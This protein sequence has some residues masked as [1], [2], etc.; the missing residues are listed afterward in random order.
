MNWDEILKAKEQD[1][2]NPLEL[3]SLYGLIEGVDSAIE[4]L[5]LLHSKH[6]QN[7]K[8]QVSPAKFKKWFESLERDKRKFILELHEIKKQIHVMLRTLNGKT[9]KALKERE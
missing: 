4:D 3:D 5:Q 6:A 1:L 8:S 7:I 9:A 2:T